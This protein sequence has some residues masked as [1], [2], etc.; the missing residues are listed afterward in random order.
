MKNKILKYKLDREISKELSKIYPFYD[1]GPYKIDIVTDSS[2]SM[3]ITHLLMSFNTIFRKVDNKK[4]YNLAKK[5][6]EFKE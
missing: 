3:R 1:N 6:Y 2:V 5:I 4:I